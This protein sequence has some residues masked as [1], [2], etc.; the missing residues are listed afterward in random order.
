MIGVNPMA[1]LARVISALGPIP[2][3]EKARWLDVIPEYNPVKY[4][5]FPA[6][7]GQQTFVVT[8]DLQRRLGR[9]G[10]DGRLAHFPP[11]LTFQSLV[12]AT[13]STPAIVANFYDRLPKN[14]SALVLFDFNR[15][16]R[17]DPFIRPEDQSLIPRL[18]GGRARN[19]RVTLVTNARTDTRDARARSVE[20]GSTTPVDESIGLQWEQDTFS[21]SHVALPFPPDDP[22][23]GSRAAESPTGPVA[24]GLLS[25]RGER[26]VLTVPVEVLMRVSSNPFFPYLAQRLS[27]WVNAGS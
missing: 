10:A 4:N 26:S 1:R 9:L 6:N 18:F 22:V 7:A 17:L 19:Y 11:V 5:S 25:P 14:G 16:A 12:D 27:A 21:L 13:V 3:F 8:Q 2:Y 23:Y 20:P 15:L 24:L